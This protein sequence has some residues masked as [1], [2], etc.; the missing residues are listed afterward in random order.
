MAKTPFNSFNLSLFGRNLAIL[1]SDVFYIDP[2]VIAGSG[3][4]Q[5][6][7][8]AQ[9]PTTRSFGMNLSAKF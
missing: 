2:Q 5:E 1:S 8:D 4:I 3:N 7:E 6:L 9:V